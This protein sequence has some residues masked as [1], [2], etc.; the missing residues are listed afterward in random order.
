M[1]EWLSRLLRFSVIFALP[2]I[3]A[4]IAFLFT[5][6]KRGVKRPFAIDPP[7]QLPA[8]FSGAKAYSQIVCPV[9]S[10]SARRYLKP[11]SRNQN[12]DSGWDLILVPE[13]GTWV[14]VTVAP[15]RKNAGD[16][17]GVP[18]LVNYA[19]LREPDV[20]EKDLRFG[21]TWSVSPQLHGKTVRMTLT[22]DSEQKINLGQGPSVYFY[23]K[24]GV[25]Y[26]G[27]VQRVINK[28]H[29]QIV[30]DQKIPNGV[31]T[32][33]FWVRLA[34]AKSVI[35]PKKGR[36]RMSMWLDVLGDGG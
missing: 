16:I 25:P 8:H 21:K 22:L 20:Q 7:P 26:N 31:T 2:F 28:G 33:Q 34:F 13:F 23:F 10:P 4:G 11:L 6:E 17:G 12:P 5:V 29:S 15:G 9:L 35:D 24:P 1:P 18:C 19:F 3:L 27:S 36:F 30:V 14:N 32:M